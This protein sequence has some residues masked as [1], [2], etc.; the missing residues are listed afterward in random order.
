MSGTNGGY[1]EKFVKQIIYVRVSANTWQYY[2]EVNTESAARE[3][4]AAMIAKGKAVL[5]SESWLGGTV[6]R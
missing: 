6:V 2:T 3:V 1:G 5:V 4:A